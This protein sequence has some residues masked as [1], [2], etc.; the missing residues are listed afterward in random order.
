MSVTATKADRV[1]LLDYDRA[2]LRDYF[3]SIGEKP[4][5]ADHV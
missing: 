5:R 2:G 1:N 4:F 3:A